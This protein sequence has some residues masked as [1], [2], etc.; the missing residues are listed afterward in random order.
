MI[1]FAPAYL[2]A[3]EVGLKCRCGLVYPADQFDSFGLCPECQLADALA[4]DDYVAPDRYSM[5]GVDLMDC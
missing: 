3:S 4:R 5:D 1:V 2:K